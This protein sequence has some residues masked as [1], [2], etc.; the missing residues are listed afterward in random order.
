MWADHHLTISSLY[1]E[2]LSG[3]MQH[4]ETL[5]FWS[6]AC[7]TLQCFNITCK[8]LYGC[9]AL[10]YTFYNALFKLHIILSS[11]PLDCNLESINYQRRRTVQFN[12]DDDHED[13][14]D[15]VDD[16]DD[17]EDDDDD[18]DTDDDMFLWKEI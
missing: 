5:K 7:I 2:T 1:W 8:M 16:D 12:N 11:N 10:H 15:V 9:S 4:F 14:D 17:D 6:T 3:G 18:D 13:Q